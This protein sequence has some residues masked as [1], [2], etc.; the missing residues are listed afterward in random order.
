MDI[1]KIPYLGDTYYYALLPCEEGYDFIEITDSD[2]VNYAS[3]FQGPKK[4][5]L[6]KD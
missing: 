1:Y 3:S 4:E 6:L 5:R 2:V